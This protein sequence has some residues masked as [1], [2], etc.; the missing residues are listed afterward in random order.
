MSRKK[1]KS[2]RK[3]TSKYKK[4]LWGLEPLTF[5]KT[6]NHYI[7]QDYVK[8]LSDK[9]KEWLSDFN[10]EYYG[11]KLSKKTLR[12]KVKKKE[13]FDQTNARNRDI[14]NIR[15]KSYLD[16]SFRGTYGSEESVINYLHEKELVSKKKNSL[17][18][19]DS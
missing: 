16:S 7:D 10:E 17:D 9:E 8:E 18:S 1:K 11:N 2:K 6:I 5:P 14:S 12:N 13:I 19:E 4:K 3:S 15:F